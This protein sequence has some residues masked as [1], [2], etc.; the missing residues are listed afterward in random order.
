MTILNFQECKITQDVH[1]NALNLPQD[2]RSREIG[3][4]VASNKK[5]AKLGEKTAWSQFCDLNKIR[6]EYRNACIETLK[7]PADSHGSFEEKASQI[8]K[9]P[10]S[11]ILIGASGRGKTMF[12]FALIRAFLENN[13]FGLCELRYFR[14]IDLEN[15]LYPESGK[16]IE[17]KYF[18]DDVASLPLLCIDDFGM[19]RDTKKIERDYYDIFDQ[20]Y[21]KNRI[22]IISTN[23]SGK[24]IRRV[25]GERIGSRLKCCTAIEFNGPDLRGRD[26]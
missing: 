11:L 25:Y 23:L 7:I 21:G 26:I 14:S 6:E 10:K 24:D 22:T 4:M 17:S 12:M 13:L 16:Y 19:E 8:L 1:K 15:R 20:R 18:I 9:N 5:N 2:R 3:P